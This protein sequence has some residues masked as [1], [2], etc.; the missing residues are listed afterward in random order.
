MS[1]LAKTV[2]SQARKWRWGQVNNSNDIWS[3]WFSETSAHCYWHV[4]STL[5]IHKMAGTCWTYEWHATPQRLEY[6]AARTKTHYF[7]FDSCFS[8][9]VENFPNM[10]FEVCLIIFWDLWSKIRSKRY[11]ICSNYWKVDCQLCDMV[12]RLFS[13]KI[14]A[15]VSWKLIFW[16]QTLPHS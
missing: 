8:K 13:M 6:Y 14:V 11:Q 7:L 4:A 3:S 12:W 15:A 2:E 1:A 10:T 5:A 9:K 16:W